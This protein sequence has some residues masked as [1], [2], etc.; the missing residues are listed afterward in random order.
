MRTA[1]LAAAL[2][3]VALT[4]PAPAL[5]AIPTQ[6]T[7]S[8]SPPSVTIGGAASCTASVESPS[9]PP[10]PLGTV[11]FT[12]QGPKTT[13]SFAESACELALLTGG[14]R[15]KVTYLPPG[16]GLHLITAT[17]L[18][19]EN[20]DPSTGQTTLRAVP[21]PKAKKCKK[22]RKLKKVKGQDGKTRRKCVRV[23]KKRK[24]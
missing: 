10:Y 13:L 6:T 19:D 18:G 9:R 16:I 11:Q 5:A 3:A 14:S 2:A 21:K 15:C 17:Y 7:V 20:H 23:K 1:I 24:R 12:A 22:G 8:C 4:A